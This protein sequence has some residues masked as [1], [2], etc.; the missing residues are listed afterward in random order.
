M[1]FMH[2]LLNILLQERDPQD[3]RP[4]LHSLVGSKIRMASP[5]EDKPALIIYRIL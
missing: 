2:H 3:L 5:P 1:A 4:L